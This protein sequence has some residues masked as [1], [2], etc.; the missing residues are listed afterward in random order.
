[1]QAKTWLDR[2]QKGYADS[3]LVVNGAAEFTS[4]GGNRSACL[5]VV[6]HLRAPELRV[7]KVVFLGVLQTGREGGRE[8]EQERE[9]ESERERE[10]RPQDSLRHRFTASV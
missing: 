4:F 8:R 10:R 5:E 7:Q 2:T 3:A 1:M 6:V 9:R